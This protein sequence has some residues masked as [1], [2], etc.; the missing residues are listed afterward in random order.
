MNKPKAY[1]TG[2]DR[3]LGHGFV[4]ELLQRG[5]EVYAGC[6]KPNEGEL[7]E[8]KSRYPAELTIVP[9]DVR[10]NDSVA[11]AAAAI[12]ERTDELHLLINNAGQAIDRSGTILDPL[13]DEDVLRLYDVNAVG[14]LRVTHSVIPL[15]R[16]AE[17]KTIVNI[18]SVAGSVASVT[19]M[20]QYGYTM[21][22]AA[23]NMQTKLLHNHLA[24]EGFRVLAIHPGWMR[25]Y[26]FEDI[27]RM[28]DAPYEPRQSA[29]QIVDLIESG[30]GAEGSLYMDN[31]GNPLPW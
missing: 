8:T 13:Y 29:K 4:V 7:P 26:L 14:P 10:D 18:S 31:E 5:Y 9:L 22:K 21:S 20:H 28:K 24:G 1:V 6:Y 17:R 11:G 27:E 3:G 25:S 15:L 30:A 23:L 19:R 16:R 12:R 2:A